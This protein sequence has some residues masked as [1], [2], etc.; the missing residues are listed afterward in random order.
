[1]YIQMKLEAEEPTFRTDSFIEQVLAKTRW[2]KFHF[3]HGNEFYC[4]VCL[5][6]RVSPPMLLDAEEKVTAEASRKEEDKA[7]KQLYNKRKMDDVENL[8]LLASNAFVTSLSGQVPRTYL[9]YYSMASTVIPPAFKRFDNGSGY[10]TLRR[11]LAGLTKLYG[12]S[13]RV[14]EEVS[15][16][17]FDTLLVRAKTILQ[18]LKSC[19]EEPSFKVALTLSVPRVESELSKGSGASERLSVS[20]KGV[21]QALSRPAEVVVKRGMK[22]TASFLGV[23]ASTWSETSFGSFGQDQVSREEFDSLYAAATEEWIPNLAKASKEDGEMYLRLLK[24]LFM[25]SLRLGVTDESHR[26]L[27]AILTKIDKDD[28]DKERFIAFRTFL[29]SGA[30]T[31][32]RA[33]D[34]YQRVVAN[35]SDL[36]KQVCLSLKFEVM[37]KYGRWAVAKELHGSFRIPKFLESVRTWARMLEC[38]IS[39]ALLNGDEAVIQKTLWDQLEDMSGGAI[40]RDETTSLSEIMRRIFMVVKVRFPIHVG[41]VSDIASLFVVVVLAFEGVDSSDKLRQWLFHAGFKVSAK[42]YSSQVQRCAHGCFE[43]GNMTHAFQL[44]KV[45]IDRDEA[46]WE[47]WLAVGQLET[48]QGKY[49]DA[50]RYLARAVSEAEKNLGRSSTYAWALLFYANLL[51]LMGYF[52]TPERL[53]LEAIRVYEEDRNLVGHISAKCCYGCLLRKRGA[54]E[55]SIKL[56]VDMLA[57]VTQI[58]GKDTRSQVAIVYTGLSADYYLQGNFEEADRY[59]VK[60]VN[61]ILE[62][63]VG[64]GYSGR[65]TFVECRTYHDWVVIGMLGPEKFREGTKNQLLYH[66]YPHPDDL[67]A[68]FGDEQ[69]KNQIQILNEAVAA[70]LETKGAS[71]DPAQ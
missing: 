42:E 19:H 9:L 58:Y 64:E 29:A 62:Q 59:H 67:S 40:Q 11:R 14:L 41:F 52:A 38:S 45:L 46:T 60:C 57:S 28:K 49:T 43:A 27:E 51:T 22:R 53:Y 61:H 33:K 18:V 66:M 2:S 71:A 35:L 3:A 56:L 6:E 48:M 47:V 24:S 55:L 1:M 15:K 5:L 17:P 30:I 63:R 10:R 23:G 65:S 25:M 12:R 50:E 68:L 39:F 13:R 34:L 32:T 8:L 31:V 69:F 44:F 20:N 21:I 26:L 36:D 70:P 7:L 54:E 16:H 37:V 4:L